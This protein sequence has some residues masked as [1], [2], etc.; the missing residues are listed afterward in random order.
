VTRA[1]QA[2]H[3]DALKRLEVE[4][5]EMRYGEVQTDAKPSCITI[6]HTSFSFYPT[7]KAVA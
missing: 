4:K 3:A 7:L 6:V 2:P 5:K 1:A